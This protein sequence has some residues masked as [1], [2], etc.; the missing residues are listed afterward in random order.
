MTA[1]YQHAV[2]GGMVEGQEKEHDMGVTINLAAVS[3]GGFNQWV[4]A[5]WLAQRD[6]EQE[7]GA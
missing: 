4:A 7:E 1:A 6:N 2:W 5:V 3:A